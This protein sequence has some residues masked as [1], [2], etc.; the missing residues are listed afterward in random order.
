MDQSLDLHYADACWLQDLDSD[1]VMTLLCGS[2]L[3]CVVLITP[4]YKPVQKTKGGEG[5]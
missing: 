2:I 3:A 4:K 1:V 5:D